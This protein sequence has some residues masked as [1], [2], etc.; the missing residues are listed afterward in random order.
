MVPANS[1]AVI[2][3]L[4]IACS[5]INLSSCR[6]PYNQMASEI[7]TTLPPIEKINSTI[8]TSQLNESSEVDEDYE[9]L[10]PDNHDKE[11]NL[12][13]QKKATENFHQGTQEKDYKILFDAKTL[14]EN[15]LSASLLEN[16][17]LNNKL[18][19]LNNTLKKIN[20]DKEQTL[21]EYSK[22]NKKYTKSLEAL[23]TCENR[24]SSLTDHQVNLE[25]NLTILELKIK[26]KTDEVDRLKNEQSNELQINQI[27]Q[28]KAIENEYQSNLT[29][30]QPEVKT[31]EEILFGISEKERVE[32]AD[33]LKIL[34]FIMKFNEDNVPDNLLEKRQQLFEKKYNERQTVVVDDL[35]KRFD[36]FAL[37]SPSQFSN[38]YFCNQKISYYDSAICALLSNDS[39]YDKID[40]RRKNLVV[41]PKDI[42]TGFGHVEQIYLSSNRLYYL[43]S[44]TFNNLSNLH[45]L[46]INNN[47][48]TELSSDI[49]NGLEKLIFLDL[50]MNKLNSI[51]PG[52]FNNLS[53]LETLIIDNNHLTAL[54]SDIF[55]GLE[56]LEELT[57]S[58]NNITF[59][60]PGTFSNL[61]NLENLNIHHNNLTEL[62][63]DMFD[64][65]KK[66]E[67]LYLSSN[68]LNS[69]QPGTFKNLSSLRKLVLFHN[70]L[71][72][73][74]KNI[75]TGLKN[76]EALDLSNNRL[77]YLDSDIFNNLPAIYHLSISFNNLTIDS[78]NILMHEYRFPNFHLRF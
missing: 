59:L 17:E 2:F 1:V 11:N 48:L 34:M 74:P 25:K 23:L 32:S 67:I 71:T 29:N 19:Q 75:F 43:E 31:L 65:L 52:A 56:K 26:N 62:S 40:L 22:I 49:F 60:Q 36:D 13:K 51:Q 55:N 39:Y 63:S 6:M 45:I 3:T 61:S 41:V 46:D 28:L 54:S 14:L 37:T 35:R 68:K 72:S 12:E 42:F 47:N 57:L 4:T 15:K 69:L 58:W 30:K 24:V 64:D 44:G 10:N 16:N 7:D 73:L 33:L 70:H 38:K 77:S 8:S 76:L 53:N 9:S 27:K 18:L 20:Q 5:F 50:T 78:K 21:A 66:L